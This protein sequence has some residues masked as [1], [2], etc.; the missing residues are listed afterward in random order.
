MLEWWTDLKGVM[1]YECQFVVVLQ[2][3]WFSI[4]LLF[5]SAITCGGWNLQS[6]NR[7]LLYLNVSNHCLCSGIS[8]QETFDVT[9]M[10]YPPNISAFVE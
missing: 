3:I 7:I 4:Q 6:E 9:E 1:R 10:I 5:F 2:M 8:L